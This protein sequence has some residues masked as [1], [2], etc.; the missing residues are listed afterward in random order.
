VRVRLVAAGSAAPSVCLDSSTANLPWDTLTRARRH[1]PTRRICCFAACAGVRR[2]LGNSSIYRMTE[3][4]LLEALSVYGSEAI[5]GKSVLVVGSQTPSFEAI[6]L[7]HGAQ[8]VVVTE[9]ML[10]PAPELASLGVSYVHVNDFNAGD[11][12]FD[13]VVSISSAEHDGLGRYG[14]PLDP[15]S[16]LRNMAA[17]MKHVKPGGLVFLSVPVGRDRVVF[18]LHRI[19]G[20]GSRRDH[21]CRAAARRVSCARILPRIA[22]WLSLPPSFLLSLPLPPPAL[23]VPC[24]V[25]LD[26]SMWRRGCSPRRLV[27]LT[28]G[29]EP[30]DSFGFLFDP[31]MSAIVAGYFHNQPVFVLRA[32][33][34]AAAGSAC[35]SHPAPEPESAATP[36]TCDASRASD[37]SVPLSDAERSWAAAASEY[38]KLRSSNTV[39]A[40]VLRPANDA[41]HRMSGVAGT[42]S[43]LRDDWVLFPG[44]SLA[45]RLALRSRADVLC[46]GPAG[47]AA[48]LTISGVAASFSE[49]MSTLT[50][51]ANVS[52][53]RCVVC[54]PMV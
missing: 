6:V 21:W 31:D 30:V 44:D 43:E 12:M 32:P 53:A 17:L 34:T 35:G 37:A 51:A 24:S 2:Q 26:V 18:N 42:D 1:A 7:A 19:Y 36:R 33:R 49:D 52:A 39:T 20:Y 45:S 22:L 4:F 46:D 5:A 3:L 47:A 25:V 8:R 54:T 9:Y 23:S 50:V 15:D 16:D 48:Q 10:P 11:E 28:A 14:D 38:L 41:L 27:L 40:N 29:W 13:A